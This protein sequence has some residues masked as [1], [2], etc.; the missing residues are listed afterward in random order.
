MEIENQVNIMLVD[1]EEMVTISI[2]SF[3]K[4]ETDY[5]IICYN[6]PLEALNY[7]NTNKI[8]VVISDYLMPDMNGLEFLDEVRKVQ[9]FSPRILLTGYADKENAI[10]AINIVGIYHYIEKPWDNNHLVMTIRNALEKQTLI[11]LLQ[12]KTLEVN[13][14]YTDLQIIRQEIAK[15]FG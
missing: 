2:S 3:L 15:H 6:N 14:A 10:K 8:N 12:D 5:N 4:L 11:R 7:V 1:D 13:K 9:P